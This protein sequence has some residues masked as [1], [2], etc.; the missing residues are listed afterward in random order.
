MAI[1]ETGALKTTPSKV[2]I[3][4]LNWVSPDIYAKQVEQIIMKLLLVY[5]IPEAVFDLGFAV[6]IPDKMS[7]T[8]GQY[9]MDTFGI[10]GYLTGKVVQECRDMEGNNCADAIAK[11][12]SALQVTEFGCNIDISYVKGK[13]LIADKLHT[14]GHDTDKPRHKTVKIQYQ[15][16]NCS[17]NRTLA[18]GHSYV[19]AKTSFIQ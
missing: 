7:Y 10:M 11:D 8:N 6:S 16:P 3:T 1:M 2:L 19:E 13:Q 4:I 12:G 14:I 17:Y 15:E 18:T 5:V 9:I